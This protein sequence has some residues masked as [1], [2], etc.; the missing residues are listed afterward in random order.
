[1]DFLVCVGFLGLWQT[2]G[3]KVIDLGNALE[4]GSIFPLVKAS[5]DSEVNSLSRE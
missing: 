4:F 3:R 2:E 5:G 1:M